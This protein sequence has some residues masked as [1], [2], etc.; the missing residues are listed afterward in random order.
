MPE[1]GNP[2]EEGVRR[3][4]CAGCKWQTAM[5]ELTEEI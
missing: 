2:A 5:A 4:T 3:G 1:Q